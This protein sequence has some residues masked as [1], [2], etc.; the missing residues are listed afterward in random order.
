MKTMYSSAT[1][2]PFV[3]R[4][5]LSGTR[6][7]PSERD[8]RYSRISTPEQELGV[9]DVDLPHFVRLDRRRHPRKNFVG[10]RGID[11]HD[12]EGLTAGAA[13]GD[14]HARDVDPGLAELMTVRRHDARPVGVHHDDVVRRNRHLDVVPVQAD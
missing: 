5:R 12:A 7:V 6:T 14:L 8:E 13:A 1:V 10:Y 4:R 2:R 3:V 11:S 9:D